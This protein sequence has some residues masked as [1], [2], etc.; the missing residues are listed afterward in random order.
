VANNSAPFTYYIPQ[1][2]D[3]G[4]AVTGI[5]DPAKVTRP[6][7]I[8]LDSIEEPNV[9]L[10][11]PACLFTATITADSLTAGQT[12]ALLRYNNYLNVPS[13]GFNPIGAN[14]VV[15]FTATS[16][17]KTFT[18]YFMS[19]SAVFYRCIPYNYTDVPV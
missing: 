19:D 18:D 17:T 8:N 7:H 13:T 4:V 9:S 5:K 14:T 6:V 2:V 10:G 12:Y 1:N 16:V 3:Y 15:Y 11:V